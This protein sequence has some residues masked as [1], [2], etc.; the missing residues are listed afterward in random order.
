MAAD[1]RRLRHRRADWT[2][3]EVPRGTPPATSP[4]DGGWSRIARERC[5]WTRRSALARPRRASRASCAAGSSPIPGA[6]RRYPHP[7]A[8]CTGVAVAVLIDEELAVLKR[9]TRR[10]RVA[11]GDVLSRGTAARHVVGVREGAPR[12]FRS[13]LPQSLIVVGVLLQQ[14]DQG[15]DRQRRRVARA[16]ATGIRRSASAPLYGAALWQAPYR[17]SHRTA[18]SSG[19]SRSGTPARPAGTGDRRRQPPQLVPRRRRYGRRGAT[20]CVRPGG[21]AG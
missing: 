14:T 15:A 21:W 19:P 12:S 5:L 7:R 3:A 8:L 16:G 13:A 18:R 20:R 10:A 9:V 4:S 11:I 1:G 2:S 6:A 17:T